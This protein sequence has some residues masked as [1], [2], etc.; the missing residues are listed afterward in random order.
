MIVPTCPRRHGQSIHG[1]GYTVLMTALPRRPRFPG[2]AGRLGDLSTR[3]T[4]VG[5][6]QHAIVEQLDQ[7]RVGAGAQVP[8]RRPNTPTRVTPTW[9]SRWTSPE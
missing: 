2:P 7:R 9:K 6:D 4:R 1:G 8:L 5:L 3:Q